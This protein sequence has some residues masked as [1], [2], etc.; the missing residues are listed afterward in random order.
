MEGSTRIGAAARRKLTAGAALHVSAITP[1]EIGMLV[2]KG[3]LAFDQDPTQW[4]ESALS[5]SGIHLAPL[6]PVTAVDASRLPGDFHGDPADCIIVS[7]SRR[8]GLTLATAD[9]AIIDYGRAGHLH[10]LAA[11]R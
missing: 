11:H 10:T 6:D 1:W 5:A 9:Q 3:R 8:L 7:T 2:A 4:I